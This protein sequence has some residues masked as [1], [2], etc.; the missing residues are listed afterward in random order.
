VLRWNISVY[1]LADGGLSPATA[2]SPQGIRLAVWQ[3]DWHGLNWLNELA[4]A[5][6]AI[7]L[8]GNGYPN[9]YTAQAVFLLPRIL[10]GPPDANQV[11]WRDE[12]DSVLPEWAGRTVIDVENAKK[13][14]ADEWLLVV[15]WDES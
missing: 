3:T 8:G 4:R 14:P 10:E 13:C 9:R 2:D 5:G 12:Y 15:A 6:N 7:N 1:P 11:W